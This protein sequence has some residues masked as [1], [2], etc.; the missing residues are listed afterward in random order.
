[1]GRIVGWVVGL[2]LVAGV[3][4]AGDKRPD[5]AGMFTSMYYNEEGTDVLGDEVFIVYTSHGFQGTF[6]MARGGVSGLQMFEPVLDGKR[7]AFTVT[8]PWGGEPLL[9]EGEID[10]EGLRGR[11]RYPD[12]E[13]GWD[14]DLKRAPSYWNSGRLSP[15]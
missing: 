7:V 6:Q 10:A 8:D 12:G 5:Y 3:A 15:P 13:R 4:W 14:A 11:F 1:M 9:F 2:V